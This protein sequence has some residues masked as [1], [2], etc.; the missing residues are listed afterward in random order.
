[1]LWGNIGNENLN[2]IIH[3]IDDM[4]FS[5]VGA[6]QD[7]SYVTEKGMDNLSNDLKSVNS[8]INLNN[9]IAG[10]NAYQNYKTNQRLK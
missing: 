2:T 10:I 1:M 5:I 3:K 8:S 4:N 6:I 9:L 7:L